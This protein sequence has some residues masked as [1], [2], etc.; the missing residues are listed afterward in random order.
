MAVLRLSLLQNCFKI[1]RLVWAVREAGG[2]AQGATYECDALTPSSHQTIQSCRPSHLQLHV[3]APFLVFVGI[4]ERSWAKELNWLR[5]TTAKRLILYR[6]RPLDPK[7]ET[8]S[9][10]QGIKPIKM[11]IFS[12]SRWKT[13][14]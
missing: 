7:E 8:L 14:R 4:Y 12:V 2:L 13:C 6:F 3:P 1:S 5:K 9:T 11:G 10:L